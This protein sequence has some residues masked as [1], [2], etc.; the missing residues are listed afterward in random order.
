MYE[1]MCPSFAWFR[2]GVRWFGMVS[3]GSLSVNTLFLH[4]RFLDGSKSRFR[5]GGEEVTN[6][7]DLL[8]C[9]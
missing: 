6:L 1:G 2:Y 4:L 3:N 7:G 8:L 5:D 9:K